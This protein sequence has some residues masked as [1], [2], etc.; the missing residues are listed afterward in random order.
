M[1]RTERITQA[2]VGIF[3]IAG[4][5]TLIAVLAVL[6]RS[7]SLFTSRISLHTTFQNTSGL[8]VGAPVRLAGVDIGIVQGIRFDRDLRVKEVHVLLRVQKK[9]QDRL[10]EDSIARL[11][12]SGLLGDM[13]INITV[14]SA[15]S[16]P[17]KDG[18]FIR[19]EESMGM[20]EIGAKVQEAI[21]SVQT[22]AHDLDQQ[23]RL[24]L[25]EQ[26]ARDAGRAASGLANVIAHVEKGPGVVHDLLYDDH[27]ARST[28]AL[29]DDAGRSAADLDR[30]LQR[31]EH[32]LAEVQ[33]GS[34]TLH[35]LIYQDDGTKLM[36]ELQQAA[37]ELS[38]VV[39]AIQR[40]D[41]LLHVLIYDSEQ[42]HLMDNLSA[43][44][45]SL[46]HLSQEVEQG[47]GTLGGLLK[48]PTVYQDLKRTLDN[49]ERNT[50]LRTLI[51]YTIKHDHLDRTTG[52]QLK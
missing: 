5:V 29:V 41:G 31:G 22:L 50:L 2:K 25:T 51:R 19:A 26:F 28:A 15:E 27:L 23:L 42:R 36:R 30:A 10:R 47:K 49:V 16:V 17:L 45:L 21:G 46:R 4:I 34:G 44:S 12:S 20:A 18:G 33:K 40:G 38:G 8:V 32:I 48:D 11:T 9:Y 14:G 52:G 6:G 39:G 37:A 1:K 7:S 24:V 43:A 35:A 3:L 13:L